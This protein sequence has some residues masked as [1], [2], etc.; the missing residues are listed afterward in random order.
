MKELRTNRRP[1][2][3][4]LLVAALLMTG[5]AALACESP[6][7]RG[8]GRVAWA[9]SSESLRAGLELYAAQEFSRAG[10]EFRS[11]AQAARAEGDRDL[12]HRARIAECSAWVRA[13][14]PQ[15]LCSCAESLAASQRRLRTGDPRVNTLIALGAIAGGQPLPTLRTPSTV[16]QVLRGAAEEGK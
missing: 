15:E 14:R 9:P 16:R 13:R 3:G 7:S 1:S 6:P 12:A 10:E 2:A 4:R 5:A 8:Y 11:A